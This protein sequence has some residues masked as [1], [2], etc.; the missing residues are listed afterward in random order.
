MVSFVSAFVQNI[1]HTKPAAL[2]GEDFLGITLRFFLC[3]M[4][5]LFRFKDPL[6]FLQDMVLCLIPNPEAKEACKL[7]GRIQ[8]LQILSPFLCGRMFVYFMFYFIC[9]DLKMFLN[10]SSSKRTKLSVSEMLIMPTQKIHYL[11]KS[12]KEKKFNCYIIIFNLV[13]QAYKI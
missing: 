5:F 10:F 1:K 9:R 3:Y 13:K 4:M 2:G 8:C 7:C 12:G 6:I 11:P